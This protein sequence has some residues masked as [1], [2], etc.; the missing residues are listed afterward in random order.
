MDARSIGPAVK[1]E[2]GQRMTRI[3]PAAENL[4]PSGRGV[5]TLLSQASERNRA[6]PFGPRDEFKKADPDSQHH[7]YR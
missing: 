7:L 6:S 2:V 1:P 4:R 5:R 3:N